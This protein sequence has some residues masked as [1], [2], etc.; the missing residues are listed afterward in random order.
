MNATLISINPL[1]AWHFLAPLFVLAAL[2]L[3]LAL[4]RGA[5]G[6]W[7]RLIAALA[8]AAVLVNPSLVKEKREPIRDVAVIA[9]DRSQ[10]QLLGGPHRA[11]PM[12]RWPI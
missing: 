4:V 8:I 5:R 3:L 6:A 12:L 10:S 11:L 9:V 1:I 7:L 2:P